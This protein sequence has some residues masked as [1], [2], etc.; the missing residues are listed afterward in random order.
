MGSSQPLG[1]GRPAPPHPAA[2]QWP[3]DRTTAAQRPARGQAATPARPRWQADVSDGDRGSGKPRTSQG[4]PPSTCPQTLPHAPDSRK[5][6][7][8]DHFEK[9]AWAF[10]RPS[11]L[12]DEE[13]T[14]PE[15]E[16]R[17]RTPGLAGDP[18]VLDNL[19]FGIRS[20]KRVRPSKRPVQY[21]GRSRAPP[22][23]PSLSPRT[24]RTITGCREYLRGILRASPVTKTLASGRKGPVASDSGVYSGRGLL[25]RGPP[26]PFQALRL[27]RRVAGYKSNSGAD[28]RS[29]DAG[30]L[31]RN[32]EDQSP[33]TCRSATG[34]PPKPSRR[35]LVPRRRQSVRPKEDT[36]LRRTTSG[37]RVAFPDPSDSSRGRWQCQRRSSRLQSADF[38][39]PD[40]GERVTVLLLGKTLPF[41]PRVQVL[42]EDA[43]GIAGIRGRRRAPSTASPSRKEGERAGKRRPRRQLSEAGLNGRSEG[44]KKRKDT[45]SGRDYNPELGQKTI[46]ITLGSLECQAWIFQAVFY[47][48]VFGWVSGGNGPIRALFGNPSAYLSF[49]SL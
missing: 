34:T 7:D 28:P 15:V 21:A 13:C 18:T 23:G 45:Q 11:N 20:R 24:R 43:R 25:A 49:S 27:P 5:C 8:P 29:E 46:R 37:R 9:A 35:R 4:S 32:L 16:H 36:E 6:G 42:E 17:Q 3:G 33:A 44:C 2:P 22:G 31:P 39:E 47:A 1:A 19:P 48:P 38:A 10:V 30:R 12:P 41:P 26:R 14:E 40:A